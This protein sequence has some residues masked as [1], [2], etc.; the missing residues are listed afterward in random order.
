MYKQLLEHRQPLDRYLSEVGSQGELDAREEGAAVVGGGNNRSG[1]NKMIQVLAQRYC[2]D[3]KSSFEELSKI[4]QKVLACRREIVEYDRL[5][6]EKAYQQSSRSSTPSSTPTTPQPDSMIPFLLGPPH[7]AQCN[8]TAGATAKP[9]CYGCMSAATEHCVALLRALAEQPETRN[10][11]VEQGLI[12]ELVNSNLRRGSLKMRRQVRAL[13]CLLI[14]DNK[15][16]TR[17][18][19]KILIR[20]V[21]AAIDQ[22][23][24]NPSVI[25]SIQHEMQLLMATIDIQDSCWEDR[26]RFIFKLFLYSNQAH[27][28]VVTEHVTLPC[29]KVLLHVMKLPTKVAE[30]IKEKGLSPTTLLGKQLTVA[31]E[32]WLAG[33]PK[34]S[35]QAWKNSQKQTQGKEQSHEKY[36]FEKYGRRWLAAMKKKSVARSQLSTKAWLLRVLFTP[37]SK[38]ARQ[39]ACSMVEALCEDDT[40]RY[41]ILDLLSSCL[42]DLGR[43]GQNAAEFLQ[44]YQKLSGPERWKSYLAIKGILPQIGV[45][46]TREIEHLT[47]LEQTTLSSDLSQGYAL[48]MLTELLASFIGHNQI[49][50]QYKSKLVATIL[51]GYL[52]L[53]RLVIQR[54]KLVDDT[55]E[56]LLQLLENMTSGTEAE[57]KSFMA[58]CVQTLSKCPVGDV[59]TPTFI[60]ERLCSIISPEDNETADFYIILDKDPAQEEFLQ[61]RMQGNP[62]SCKEPSLGPLMR[63]IKNKI[64]TDCEL[65]ALLD[66]DTGMELLVK[67]K[68]ISLD[69]PVKEVYKKVWCKD[70][71]DA[72][73][74]MRVLYRMR[75]LLGEATEDMIQS[76]DSTD[77]EKDDEEVYQLSS[78]LS[79]C[80]GLEAVLERFSQL[81]SL[82]HGKQMVNALLKLLS[83]GVKVKANRRHLA[84]PQLNALNVMLHTLN[85]VEYYTLWNKNCLSFCGM[86]CAARLYLHDWHTCFIPFSHV[87]FRRTVT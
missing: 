75:G 8:L 44:L 68:I 47:E 74:P 26:L 61:G 25:S 34:H 36:L 43:A 67:N 13:I 72:D 32:R 54:T 4:M 15:V 57:T 53:K 83:Y 28:P 7:V 84:Q 86:L 17:R 69:L 56:L 50:Q 81:H 82:I 87:I 60:A 73:K 63:D 9:D 18:L 2:G 12:Q 23:Q 5:Q 65:V 70:A 42:G 22:H 31:A 30:Q 38:M 19:N 24:H 3:C 33:D 79:Q 78:V 48:K 71:G 59:L 16:S 64:C 27:S 14:R 29:L 35:F 85:Q 46:M 77:G 76:L 37:S 62:Y 51:D 66:D 58:I 10:M 80:S 40:R 20:Q 49:R 39:V 52:A 55:Q 1:V 45:L 21:K 11:L 41:Q 6:L